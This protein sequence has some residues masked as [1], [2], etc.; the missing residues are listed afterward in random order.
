[1]SDRQREKK[2]KQENKKA[3]KSRD[4]EKEWHKKDKMANKNDKKDSKRKEGKVKE[5][6]SLRYLPVQ[7]VAQ[8]GWD[9]EFC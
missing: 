6:E 7:L 9:Y 1:M 4:G 5:D 3:G 2:K 8:D